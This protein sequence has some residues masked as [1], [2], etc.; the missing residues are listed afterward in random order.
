MAKAIPKLATAILI[1]LLTWTMSC[2]SGLAQFSDSN[3]QSSLKVPSEKV[4]SPNQNFPQSLADSSPRFSGVDPHE[5][6]PPKHHK[7]DVKQLV[8]DLSQANPYRLMGRFHLEQGSQQGYLVLECQLVEG[9]YIHS[10]TL[11]KELSPT[12]IQTQPSDEYRVGE[13]F[14]PDRPPT[15]IEKDP[16]FGERMEKHSGKIQFFVP[17]QLAPDVNPLT[18]EP[19]MAFN[20]QVCSTS[21]TCLPIRN[22][23]VVAKF[24][25]YFQR[26]VET[27]TQDRQTQ[28]QQQLNR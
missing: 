9:S 12:V 10:L 17:I 26:P 24:A 3:P 18:L 14:H 21:G 15:V 22:Q 19:K 1:P 7:D 25:G 13:R 20:G 8:P 2:K 23:I 11:P 28:T 6:N 27:A 16:V 4:I 5:T